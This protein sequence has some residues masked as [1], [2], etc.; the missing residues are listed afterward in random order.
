MQPFVLNAIAG[1]QSPIATDVGLLILR[2]AVAAVFIAH[3]WGDVFEAGVSNN[4]ENYRDAGIPLPTLSAPFAAYV[5][6]IGGV[7]LVFGALTR[8]LSA[9]FIIVMTG[10]LT[11]VHAGES[12]VMGQDGSG[13]GYAFIM[14][15]ASIMLLLAGPGRLSLDRLLAD[16]WARLSRTV[17]GSQ[18]GGA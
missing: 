5:Q 17:R 3:G 2:L 8:P 12:L 10:A 7:L 14:C 13:A 18:T 6:L 4:V 16:R 11:F 1:T 9:G 15:A